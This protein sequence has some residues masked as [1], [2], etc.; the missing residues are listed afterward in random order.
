[1][2][3]ADRAEASVVKSDT[4]NTLNSGADGSASEEAGGASR[5]LARDPARDLNVVV[6][7]LLSRDP[8]GLDF[9]AM[10]RLLECSYDT[11]PRLGTSQR[12]S[13]DAVRFAQE[14]SLAF[15][16]VSVSKFVAK[17]GVREGR[18][19]VNFLGMLG[20]NGPLPLHI[21]DYARDRERNQ[22]DPTLARFLDVF[23]HRMVSLFY[24][25]W[26]VNQL[27]VSFDRTR[28]HARGQP[29]GRLSEP[30]PDPA[31]VDRATE[32]G[33]RAAWTDE[34]RYATYIGALFGMGIPTFRSRDDLPD[35]AKL[36][37][38][39]RL[40]P[41]VK[42]A[43]GL[44]AIIESF[45]GVSARIEEFVGGWLDLPERYWCRL[46]GSSESCGLGVNT[47]VGA[48][49]W[50]SQGR[51]RIVMGPMALADYERLLPGGESQKR[52]E[53]WVRNYVGHEFDFQVQLILREDAV[54]KVQLGKTGQLGWTTW[55]SREKLG[56]DPS[57]LIFG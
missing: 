57:D 21:T 36:H 15:P 7:K 52:L 41:G 39:G 17:S 16:P 4:R 24:R 1:L 35:V 18:V 44:R 33:G 12:P 34:D 23:N 30:T 54:P 5:D 29:V 3:D 47:V 6:P 49:V 20:P 19:F 50:E 8:H 13:D 28:K 10:A 56:R 45:F 25:A 40:A 55:M 11:L 9:F 53:A 32:N 46:G 27:P 31:N 2:A 26:A 42:N 22:Q 43:E 38:A 48:R 51:F 14:P 37:Y